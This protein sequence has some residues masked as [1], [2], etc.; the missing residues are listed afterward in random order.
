MCEL[1]AFN[2]NQPVRPRFTFQNFINRS[3]RHPHGWGLSYYPDHTAQIIKEA[4][5]AMHSDMADYLTDYALAQSEIIMAHIRYGNVGGATHANT[6]PFSRTLWGKHWVFMHNGTLHDAHDVLRNNK[7]K[8]MGNTD[9]EM[10]FCYLLKRLQEERRVMRQNGQRGYPSFD[11]MESVLKDINV[12]GR[13][14]VVFSDG[15]Y[16]YVYRD[17]NGYNGLSYLQRRAPFNVAHYE[18]MDWTVDLQL[19]KDPFVQGVIISSHPQTRDENWLEL[20]PGRL[21]VFKKGEKMY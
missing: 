3:D 10:A 20:S 19:E 17:E 18:D 5:L 9:S 21:H 16:M 8:P 15:E 2:F 6:H 1:L 14:N 12:N 7:F 4:N 13:F 11:F